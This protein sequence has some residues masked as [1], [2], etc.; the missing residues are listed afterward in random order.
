MLSAYITTKSSTYITSNLKC[1]LFN[2]SFSSISDVITLSN[3]INDKIYITTD[4]NNVNINLT[5]TSQ[6]YYLVIWLEDD[7]TLQ[8]Q[9]YSK[10]FSGTITFDVGN[11]GRVYV[12]FSA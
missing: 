4:N 11:N 3:V 8:N 2:S 1:Q 12:D 10:E 7:L 9:D 6:T 5:N